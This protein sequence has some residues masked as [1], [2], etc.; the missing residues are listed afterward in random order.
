MN[1]IGNSSD[2]FTGFTIFTEILT[3]IIK[4]P[5]KYSVPVVTASHSF[6]FLC[7]CKVSLKSESYTACASL[8][9]VSYNL[10]TT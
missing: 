4:Y 3:F 7:P 8:V 5:I 9:R 6:N 1:E 10:H 2:G